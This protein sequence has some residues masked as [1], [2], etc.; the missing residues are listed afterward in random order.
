MLTVGFIGLET[1]KLNAE[2]PDK[3]NSNHGSLDPGASPPEN[4]QLPFATES[5]SSLS[6]ADLD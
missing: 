4:R 1:L 2:S 5:A 3:A 6:A